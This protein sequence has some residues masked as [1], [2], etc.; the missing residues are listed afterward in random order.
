MSNMRRK[1]KTLTVTCSEL[2]ERSH[3]SE[4][5]PFVFLLQVGV[6]RVIAGVTVGVEDVGC[7]KFVQRSESDTRCVPEANGAVFMSAN[8][9]CLMTLTWKGFMGKKKNQSGI[10]MCQ[11]CVCSYCATVS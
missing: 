9:Q 2:I 6:V 4:R 11:E 1:R 3:L 8:T 10:G 5:R 7:A